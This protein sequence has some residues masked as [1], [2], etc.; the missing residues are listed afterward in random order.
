MSPAKPA[1]PVNPY[2]DIFLIFYFSL[3]ATQYAEL[4]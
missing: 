1:K 3:N 4:N 2:I